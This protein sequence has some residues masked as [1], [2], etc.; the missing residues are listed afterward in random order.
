MVAS[1]IINPKSIAVIGGS[2]NISKPGGKILK[3]L[4]EGT[5]KGKLYVVNHNDT[6][7][8]G[9]TTV[10]VVNELPNIDMAIIAIGAAH[11]LAVV[12]ELAETKNTKGF[13]IISAGFGELSE[14]GKRV[15]KRLAEVVN[16]VN[17]TLIGPNCIGLIN[18][19]YQGVFTSPIP[20]LDPQGCDFVSSS[21]AVAVFFLEVAIPVGLRFNSIFSIGNGA[22]TTVEDVLEY[23]DESFDHETSSR[24]KLVYV[25][26]IDDPA[27]FLKH[28]RSLILKGCKIAAIKGGDTEAGGRAAAS[29]TGAMANSA[30]ATQALF[31]KAGI[32]HC[33]S[34][35]EMVSVASVFTYPKLPGKNIAIVTHAGGSA[36]LLTDALTKGGLNVPKIEGKQAENL[37]TYLNPGSSVS[38]P[39]DFLATGTAEQLG[40]IIDY[41]NFKFKNID[42]IIVVFGS[43]G[44]FDVQNVYKVLN[45]KVEVSEIPIFPVLPSILNADKEIKYFLSQGHV[46]F[47]DE[48]TLAKA[49]CAVYNTNL[50]A[51]PK[52]LPKVDKNKIQ[53]VLK[54]SKPNGEGLLSQNT[55]L[56]LLDAAQIA[57]THQYSVKTI[58][59]AVVKANKIGYPI[60]LKVE[61]ISHKTEVHGVVLNIHTE[62]G[63]KLHYK[64]LMAIEGA[65]GVLLQEMVRGNELFIGAKYEKKFGHLVLV[66]IGGIFLELLKDVSVGLSPLNRNEVQNMIRNLKGYRII[67]GY[68]GKPGIDEET[69]IDMVL[70]VCA[71]LEA[72][73]EIKEMDINPII[74]F[75][76]ELKAT[77]VRIKI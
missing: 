59:D 46:N 9:I 73:P 57:R 67:E 1:E 25:E 24:T 75:G 45:V 58:E 26:N 27:K 62:K 5:F 52:A 68:R 28:S 15:E 23:M 17:G 43:P 29:H 76:N 61:G 42:A 49:L 2:R 20:K 10:P 56:E 65:T 37:L 21:G 66:G 3:N 51:E 54:S 70:N 48:V 8:Q 44:L 38:N 55:V 34:R 31:D 35:E 69:L 53:K 71:L 74:G 64:R 72:A 14:E 39:I 50:P 30:L 22:H 60:A 41:C 13:I 19:H 12:E 18:E 63:L 6:D 7:V 4:R 32:V 77:D 11:A 40:I 47:P 16:S 36:V 33:I